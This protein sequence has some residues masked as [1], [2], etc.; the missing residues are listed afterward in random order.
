[1]YFSHKPL[2]VARAS[3]GAS[4]ATAAA[5][6]NQLDDDGA[7]AELL[8][9]REA[10]AAAHDRYESVKAQFNINS[11]AM[12]RI[13]SKSRSSSINLCTWRVEVDIGDVIAREI[14]C[15]VMR[16]TAECGQ[17]LCDRPG[18]SKNQKEGLD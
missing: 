2:S 4:S 17:K 13:E 14:T 15:A 18:V 10:T 1:M 16:R 5:S 8:K 9:G 6:A 7:N 12:M 3:T 11:L